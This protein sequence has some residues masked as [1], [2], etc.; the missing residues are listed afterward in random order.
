MTGRRSAL[1]AGLI[2]LTSLLGWTAGGGTSWASTASRSPAVAQPANVLE[3]PVLVAH[4]ADGTVS[5]REVGSGTPLLLIMG[6][7]GSMDFWAPSFVNT[8]AAHHRVVIFDNAG[9]GQTAPLA[10]TLTIPA[11]ATQTSALISTLKLGRTAVLGWSMGGMIAQALVIEHPA[12]VGGLVLAATQAGN[13]KALPVPAAAAAAL[14]SPNPVVALSALFPRGQGAAARNYVT[15]LAQY[16]GFYAP[17]AAVKES[18]S[19]AVG[20]W[21]EGQDAVGSKIGEVKSPTLVAD[22]TLDKLDPTANDHM[23]AGLIPGAKL[24]LYPD[25]GHAFLFQDAAEFL[26]AVQRFLGS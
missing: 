25:A 12:E 24:L 16:P 22:G 3:A 19:L 18:Q 9:I 4:T 15:S 13:G 1:V 17:T 10:P 23:L 20:Q 2:A 6:F 8:L 11:M 5:Y 21:L 14:A 26:P 7:G